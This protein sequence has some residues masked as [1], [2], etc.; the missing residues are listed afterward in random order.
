MI[1]LRRLSVLRAVAHYGTVT[2]AAEAVHLTPSAASQ[3]IR[4]LSKEL[5][6]ALLERHG[7]RVRLTPAAR[8]L[9]RHAD[10]IAEYWQEAEAELHTAHPTALRGHVR[11]AGFPTAVCSLLAPLAAQLRAEG[12]DLTVELR[13]AEP[14]ECFDLLFSGDADLAVVEA[15]TDSPPLNDARFHQRPLMD[16]AFDLLTPADHPLATGPAPKLGELADEPWILAAPPCSARQ[17]VLAACTSAGFTPAIAHQVSEW[18][19]VAT[20]VAHGLGIALVP[21]VVQLPPQLN[22]ARTPL[23]GEVRPFRRLLRVVRSGD[24]RHPTIAAAASRLDALAPR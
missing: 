18:S 24:E 21:R 9:L 5:D 4:Q 7:R 6:V 11:L 16:D 1:D 20:L 22:L 14:G 15:T 17:L 2:A 19:V 12:P 23:D 13:Q 8:G 10:R 3:Q